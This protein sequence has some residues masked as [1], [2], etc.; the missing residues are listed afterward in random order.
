MP[1]RY[2]YLAKKQLVQPVQLFSVTDSHLSD[3]DTIMS[4]W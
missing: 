4:A 2:Y 1:I 3:I